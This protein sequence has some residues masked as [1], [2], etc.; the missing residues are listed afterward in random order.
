MLS[1]DAGQVN[2]SPSSADVAVACTAAGGAGSVVSSSRTASAA[3][4]APLPLWEPISTRGALPAVIGQVPRYRH[5]AQC[6][7]DTVRLTEPWAVSI[8]TRT[9]DARC[10]VHGHRANTSYASS[11]GRRML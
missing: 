3:T 6:D 9:S 10:V 2:D 5:S 4:G 7:C 8:T 11:C 1:C